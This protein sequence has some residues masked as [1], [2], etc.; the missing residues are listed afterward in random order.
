[1]AE[2]LVTVQFAHPRN[3]E[4]VFMVETTLG[5]T[6]QEAIA[7]LVLGDE[8]GPFL[9]PAPTGRPYELVLARTETAITPHMTLKEAGVLD[10]DLIAVLQRGQGARWHV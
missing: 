8:D 10:G 4:R 6:G 9:E 2:D 5:C 7:G 1:M 3:S